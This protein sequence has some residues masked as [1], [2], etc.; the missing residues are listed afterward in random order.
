VNLHPSASP[1]CAQ[2][3]QGSFLSHLPSQTS[4]VES[5]DLNLRRRHSLHETGIRFRFLISL[6][7]LLLL[8]LLL[9]F[10]GD[11]SVC[12][13]REFRSALGGS[14]R[15]SRLLIL[16]SFNGSFRDTVDL[17][18]SSNSKRD[19]IRLKPSAIKLSR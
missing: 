18:F 1:L 19:T 9:A 2:A 13:L 6:A 3:V 15:L 17:A 16:F 8:L 10:V 5:S 12:E 7:L 4:S 14:S 11:S